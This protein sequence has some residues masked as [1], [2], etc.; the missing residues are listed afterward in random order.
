MTKKLSSADIEAYSQSS[1]EVIIP[2][3]VSPDDATLQM[4]GLEILIVVAG[5]VALPILCGF[6]SN[7][8]YN[9]WNRPVSRKE[10]EAL[11]GELVGKTISREPIVVKEKLLTDA[12]A[13]LMGEGLPEERA[14]AVAQEF[15]N[16][17]LAVADPSTAAVR[18]PAATQK[19]QR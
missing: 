15:L 8:L 11:R 5:K 19:E 13:K 9:Q 17:A 3:G 1:T 14:Q 18:N 2:P 4:T 6:V 16:Q 12:V 7:A 10:L